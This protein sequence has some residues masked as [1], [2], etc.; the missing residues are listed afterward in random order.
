MDINKEINNVI[1]EKK[2]FDSTNIEPPSQQPSDKNSFPFIAG[3]LLIIA[4]LLGLINWS[5]V[6]LLDVSTLGSFFDISQIQE[7]YPSITYEQ[8]LGFMQTCAII[9]I[10]I[11]IFPILGGLLAIKKK[12]YY[13]AISCS[14]IGLFS[15]GIVLT[16]SILSLIALILLILSRKQFQ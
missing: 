2:P 7:L 13:L 16:S 10:I 12:L 1:D 5:Q 14:I 8:L 4:G 15:I 3:L 11:S 9:G 6:F